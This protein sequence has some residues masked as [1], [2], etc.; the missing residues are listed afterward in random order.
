M[1]RNVRLGMSPAEL[2]SFLNTS[3]RLSDYMLMAALHPFD[4]REGEG[5][6]LTVEIFSVCSSM[7][8][9][10]STPLSSSAATPVPVP[11]NSRMPV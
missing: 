9:F 11:V 3:R 7:I 1:T 5:H 6:Q 10:G 8:P 2:K 4:A